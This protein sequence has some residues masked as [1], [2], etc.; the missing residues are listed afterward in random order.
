MKNIESMGIDMVI[1]A[2]VRGTGDTKTPLYVTIIV[3]IINLILSS[4]L[5]FGVNIYGQQI[6][7]SM[8]V[9][10]TAIAMTT[11]R[12][13]GGLI[14]I[15]VLYWKKSKFDIKIKDRY[16]LNMDMML[17]IIKIGVP[18][19]LEQ[20]VM[21]GGFLLVQ[22]IVISMGTVSSAA[23]QTG[24]NINSL[25]FMP[26]FGL[27]IAA[28]TIVGQSLGHKDFEDAEMY[29]SISNRIAII[30]I[31]IIGVLMFVFARQ[32]AMLYTNDEQV[33][34]TSIVVIRI[35]VVLEPCFAIMNVCSGVLRAAGDII[36]TT[37]TAVIGLW[38]FRIL[39]AYLLVRFYNMGLYG[40]M[41]GIFLDST[42]R[43]VMYG[44]RVKKGKWKYLKV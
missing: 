39:L 1:A 44:V 5:V 19:F 22:V 41:I 16:T 26:I 24:M 2:A 25:A 33:I 34:K 21:Q 28:T 23:Y 3:N 8:G 7:P 32:L 42:L 31:T 11:A 13:S 4:I 12:I 9:K 10:G 18:A 36:F 37:V 38:T 27:A 20:L 6:V 35:F 43:A 30:L 17:R 14:R 15:I 29:A 40:V